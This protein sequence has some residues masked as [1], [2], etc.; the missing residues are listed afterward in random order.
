MIFEHFMSN[1]Q[2]GVALL[3]VVILAIS[4]HEMAHAWMAYH[5]GDS[6][7]ARMGRLTLNPLVHFDPVGL[8]CIF[9]TPFGWGKPVMCKPR[10]SR[11]AMLISAAGP[12]SNFVQAIGLA[13]LFRLLSWEPIRSGL[14]SFSYGF[15]LWYA[16]AMVF[17]LGVEINIGLAFFNL[18]PLYP[19]DGEKILIDLLPEPQANRMEEFRQY[20]TPVLLLLLLS[21]SMFHFP[22]LSWYLNWTAQPLSVLLLGKSF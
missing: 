2:V 12:F 4:M 15:S 20:S 14:D 6:T 10:D 16:S 22:I 13:I 21:G 7:A 18:I 8:L 19:L 9:F 5:L 3:G 1:P 11:E 17:L